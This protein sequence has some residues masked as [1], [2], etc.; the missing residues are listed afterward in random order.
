MKIAIVTAVW[1]RPRLT[2]L[3]LDYYRRIAVPGL[4]LKRYGA[5]TG[6]PPPVDG[7][8][9]VDVPNE[10]LGAKWNAACEFAYD[11][12]P[13]GYL[14]VGSDDLIEPSYFEFLAQGD[15][16]WV[17]PRTLF[18][19]DIPTR[20]C[21]ELYRAAPGAGRYFS[22]AHMERFGGRPFL[23]ERTVNLDADPKRFI[24]EL[25]D[26]RRLAVRSYC[27]LDLKGPNNMH[28]FDKIAGVASRRAWN[29]GD[30]FSRFRGMVT[31][32]QV[33]ATEGQ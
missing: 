20:R 6:S 5:V 4:T 21:V 14:I 32:E 13:D 22:R 15:Y 12:D 3:V 17:E 2:E 25:P 28:S 26:H 10:P 16:D 30:V 19:Y 8:E 24:N 9:Y 11:A 33:L 31:E 18:M 1:G 7:W 23:D 29:P 27:I